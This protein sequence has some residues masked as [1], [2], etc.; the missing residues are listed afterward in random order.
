M[1]R[2]ETIEPYGLPKI[3]K[4]GLPVRPILG[5]SESLYHSIVKWLAD[6]EPTWK[7]ICIDSFHDIFEFIDYIKELNVHDKLILSL[8]VESPFTNVPLTKTISFICEYISDNEF[9]IELPLRCTCNVQFTLNDIFHRQKDGITMGSCLG[10][11]LAD[12]IMGSLENSR[13]KTAI[14]KFHLY[15]RY[16]TDVFIIRDNKYDLNRFLQTFNNCHLAIN[17]TE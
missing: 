9:N 10:P 6:L 5:M 1:E 7:R 8:G 11:L 12:S 14:D 16:V 13:L 2:I 17:F 15:K 4:P 3:H